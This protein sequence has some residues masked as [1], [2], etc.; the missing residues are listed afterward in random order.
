M[1]ARVHMWETYS[2]IRASK[3][4]L[5]TLLFHFPFPFSLPCIKES[6]PNYAEFALCSNRTQTVLN[7]CHFLAC[8]HPCLVKFTLCS[9][10]TQTMPNSWHFL[11][12]FHP[13]LVNLTSV[14]IPRRYKPSSYADLFSIL[15]FAQCREVFL[16]AGWGP[17]LSSLQGHDD[18]ISMQ[19]AVGFDGKIA[20]VGSLNFGVTEESIAATT[21]LP[22]MGDRWF[23]NHQLPR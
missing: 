17:F 6:H 5:G 16:H 22:R 3:I 15:D 7:L 4:G 12:R 13:C 18:S 14:T 2:T 20:H 11:A 8:L 21:K 23:K 1:E 19:F 10:C 9:N